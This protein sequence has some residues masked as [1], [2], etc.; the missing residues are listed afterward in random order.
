MVHRKVQV[1]PEVCLTLLAGFNLIKIHKLLAIGN[2]I[3][4]EGNNFW[5]PSRA[6]IIT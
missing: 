2:Q 6:F 1:T 5:N 3:N 4:N